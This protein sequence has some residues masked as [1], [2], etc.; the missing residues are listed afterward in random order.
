MKP[1]GVQRL[2]LQPWDSSVKFNANTFFKGVWY[3]AIALAPVE[4]IQHRTNALAFPEMKKC[5]SAYKGKRFVF[6][7][8]TEGVIRFVVIDTHKP[9]ASQLFN[10]EVDAWLRALRARGISSKEATRMM[11][12]FPNFLADIIDE[13]RFVQ[14]IIHKLTSCSSGETIDIFLPRGYMLTD[15]F[16]QS[17]RAR[18]VSSERAGDQIEVRLRIA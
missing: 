9:E 14:E 11:F 7:L 3:G 16:R 5:F 13:I 10:K 8:K 6:A 4:I 18:I 17:P 15:I 2:G 1:S 12:V